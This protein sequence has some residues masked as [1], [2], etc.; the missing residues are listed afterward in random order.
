MSKRRGKYTTAAERN[1]M[2][3]TNKRKAREAAAE[4]DQK[5]AEAAEAARSRK[6]KKLQPIWPDGGGFGEHHW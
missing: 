6:Q 1:R 3:G 2:E 4:A 5:K